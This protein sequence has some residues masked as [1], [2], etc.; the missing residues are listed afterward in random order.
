MCYGNGSLGQLLD[1]AICELSSLGDKY[2][3]LSLCFKGGCSGVCSH[4][5]INLSAVDL[6]VFLYVLL[7]FTFILTCEYTEESLIHN[8]EKR[9]TDQNAI[10]NISH[11]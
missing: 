3:C 10:I 7:L 9:I 4:A 5:F 8:E 1:N 2:S 11:Y 6:Y